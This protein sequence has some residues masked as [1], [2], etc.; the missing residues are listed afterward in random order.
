MPGPSSSVELRWDSRHPRSTSARRKAVSLAPVDNVARVA[1][2][3]EGPAA[4][5]YL[6]LMAKV[7]TRFGFEGR[8][9]TVKLP[10]RSYESF[11]WDLIL[12][13]LDNRD[14]RLVE[15]AEFDSSRRE[16]GRDWPIDAETMIGMKRLANLRSCV[17]SVIAES[18]PGDLI[19]TGVWR[20]GATIYMRAILKVYEVTNR[21]VWVADSFEGLPKPDTRFSADAG[22]QHHLRKELAISVEDVRDNFRRYDLLD[23]QVKFLVGWFAHTLPTAP[24]DQLAVLR[25][26]GDMYV[27]TMDALNALYHKVNVGG[28]VIVDDYGA[29]PACA[30][31]VDDFRA[32]HGIISPLETIDW[33]GAFWRKS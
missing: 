11:L 33:T 18:I 12:T 2:M 4:D 13:N 14:V 16:E 26:D 20:G 32:E 23:D 31:A 27:S 25:L 3:I 28:Y 24:I 30:Q 9:V 8:N 19:E 6:D 7:L 21:T 29:V 15:R 5:L 22:D 10:P 1:E 17:E